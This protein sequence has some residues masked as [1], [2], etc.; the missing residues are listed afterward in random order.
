MAMT[1]LLLG[2]SLVSSVALSP[3][4]AMGRSAPIPRA[5][6]RVSRRPG[7]RWPNCCSPGGCTTT[8]GFWWRARRRR[9]AT[10]SW[11]RSWP[12]SVGRSA[13]ARSGGGWTAWHHVTAAARSL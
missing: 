13:R 5:S 4:P 9:P 12:R 2:C 8:T 6:C 7:P 10:P 3:A 11:T 1:C